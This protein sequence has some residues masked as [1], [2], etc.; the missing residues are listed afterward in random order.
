MDFAMLHPMESSSK[1][2][3]GCWE[4]SYS[5]IILS[6]LHNYYLDAQVSRY[7]K[8]WQTNYIHSYLHDLV[9]KPF[10]T[11]CIIVSCSCN[12]I[13]YLSF[14]SHASCFHCDNIHLGSYSTPRHEHFTFDKLQVVASHQTLALKTNFPIFNIKTNSTLNLGQLAIRIWPKGALLYKNIEPKI[15]LCKYF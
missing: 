10:V 9:A 13:N 2:P 7:E 8:S 3:M 5:W 15:L 4:P 1:V 14:I 12:T 6:Y 11:Y